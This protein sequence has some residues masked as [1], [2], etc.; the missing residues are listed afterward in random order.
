MRTGLDVDAYIAP[1]GRKGAEVTI[2]TAVEEY[3]ENAGKALFERVMNSVTQQIW[4]Q[5]I[6]EEAMSALWDVINRAARRRA[7]T[8]TQ[9]TG[10]DRKG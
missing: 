10:R 8:K 5:R 3:D 4:A 6:E 1:P 9:P 7:T 2:P